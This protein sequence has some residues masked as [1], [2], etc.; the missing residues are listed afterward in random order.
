MAPLSQ[1]DRAI[2]REIAKKGSD[3]RFRKTERGKFALA[4]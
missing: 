3:S 1:G 4:N 2:I